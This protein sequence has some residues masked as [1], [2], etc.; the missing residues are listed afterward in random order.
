MTERGG[1]EA[2]DT[3]VHCGFC[4]QACPTFLATGD[5][6]DS[7]RGRIELMRALEAGELPADDPYLGVHLD[8]CLGC[9]GCEPVCPSGV[10]YGH[11]IEA[12]RERLA[13]A[14]GVPW[15]ARSA[16]RALTAPG[17][18]RAVYALARAV[19]ASGLPRRLAGWGETSHHS[20]SDGERRVRDDAERPPRQ[21]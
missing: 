17:V 21:P 12:A 14:R 1:F 9:R 7:P 13:R 11:G 8:R 3:C 2:L 6:A 4:L 20:G 18:S 15:L 5:E 10:G 16:L 19:R